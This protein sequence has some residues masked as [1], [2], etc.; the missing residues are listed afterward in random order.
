MAAAPSIL[1]AKTPLGR[2]A[3]HNL[4]RTV[5]WP[6]GQI[7][8]GLS[9]RLT[10][11]LAIA[12]LSVAAS[13]ACRSNTASD[14]ATSAVGNRDVPPG[15]DLLLSVRSEPRSLSRPAAQDTPTN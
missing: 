8:T 1:H 15:G 9:R 5:F 10:L 14:G 13:P 4:D 3:A 2:L 6:A 12:A 7:L 11:S